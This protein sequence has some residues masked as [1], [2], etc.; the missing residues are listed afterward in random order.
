M[1]GS[2][3]SEQRTEPNR[4]EP[5]VSRPVASP[6]RQCVCVCVE[7]IEQSAG[8]NS[9]AGSCKGHSSPEAI[10]C[11]QLLHTL[12]CISRVLQ[13]ELH[14]YRLTESDAN[15]LT[16]S[17][18]RARFDTLHNAALT[19]FPPPPGHSLHH[20]IAQPES[21]QSSIPPYPTNRSKFFPFLF[22]I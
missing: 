9:T 16:L 8:C 18:I 4:T 10:R 5:P 6:V 1:R 14:A 17:R 13:P 11:L 21:T 15:T 2:S 19:L 20:S 3:G 22:S 7:S 12:T